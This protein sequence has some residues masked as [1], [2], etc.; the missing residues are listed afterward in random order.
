MSERKQAEQ[1]NQAWEGNARRLDGSPAEVPPEAVQQALDMAFQVSRLDY[2]SESRRRESLR[3][4][5]QAEYAAAPPLREKKFNWMGGLAALG[6]VAGLAILMACFVL[7]LSWIFRSFLP[8]TGP[9]SESLPGIVSLPPTTAP[10]ATNP[11]NTATPAIAAAAV[12]PDQSPEALPPVLGVESSPDTIRN[13]MQDP[14]WNTIWLQG[15]ILTQGADGQP[16][17]VQVEAWMDKEGRGRV[18]STAPLGTQT[19]EEPFNPGQET[20]QVWVSDG[21]VVQRFDRQ[22]GQI[23]SASLDPGSPE[24]LLDLAGPILDLLY[25]INLPTSADGMEVLQNTSWAGRQAVQ[26]DWEG[27]SYWVDSATGQ[28]LRLQKTGSDDQVVQE[29][30]LETVLYDIPLTEE[31]LSTESLAAAT[32]HAAGSAATAEPAVTA[33][34][35]IPTEVPFSPPA[36]PTPAETSA[37]PIRIT[38]ADDTSS[39][40][41]NAQDSGELYFT[42]RSL[43]APVER[44]MARLSL[45]CLLNQDGCEAHLVENAPPISD[46][47]LHWSPDGEKAVLIDPNGNRLWRFDAQ[48]ET[49]TTLAEDL[50]VTTD[51]ASWSP[52]GKWI[53]VTAQSAGLQDSLITLVAPEVGPEGARVKT[54]AQNLGGIQIPLGWQDAGKVVFL[55]AETAPKGSNNPPVDPGLFRLDTGSGEVEELDLE[56]NPAWLAD[57]PALTRGGGRLALS[58]AQDGGVAVYNLESGETNRLDLGGGRVAW[59]PKGDRIAFLAARESESGQ[60]VDVVVADDNGA[61]KQ[62]VFEWS[63][64]PQVEWT[65][66]G[67]HLLISVGPAGNESPDN[68]SAVYLVSLKTGVARRL[69]LQGQ[70]KVYEFIAPAVRPPGGE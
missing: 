8:G 32:F 20:S 9:A 64:V 23:D 69:E 6:S 54:F 17:V 24:Q 28:I 44:R 68:K 29:V 51:M 63:S 3:R 14:A 4:Q 26:V 18:L 16:A 36:T 15:D 19:L 45:S 46:N 34:R 1:F 49:W 43:A 25:A 11:V 58:L 55:Q 66:D 39:S 38:L 47:P 10:Q 40:P 31:A 7:G 48:G 22:T 60:V 27:S 12:S 62:K 13:Q 70:Q 37:E 33:E 41:A 56:P 50:L 21:Q 59:S 52:D 5:L 67:E 57:Y 2:S 30:S 35:P 42:L 65:P 53:A 61:N